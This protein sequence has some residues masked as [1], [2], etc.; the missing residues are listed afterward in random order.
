[1]LTLQETSLKELEPE[2]LSADKYFLR[3]KASADKSI[4]TVSEEFSTK[5]KFASYKA[6]NESNEFVGFILVYP[7]DKYDVA[8]G[9][10]FVFPKFQGRKYAQQ[11]VSVL[12]D[13]YAKRGAK[14]FYTRTWSENTASLKTFLNLGFN[15][16]E[17]IPKE[18]VNDDDTVKLLLT[19]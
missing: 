14:T 11:M 19:L 2:I 7:S 13:T 18:R 8:I 12:I 16:V 9:A 3:S 15:I 10:M 1:M 5:P 17:T 6:I 4:Y